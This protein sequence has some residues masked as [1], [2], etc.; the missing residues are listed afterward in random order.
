[1]YSKIHTIQHRFKL[2]A[3]SAL[4]AFQ[5]C[6]NVLPMQGVIELQLLVM[7]ISQPPQVVHTGETSL[8]KAVHVHGEPNGCEPSTHRRGVN[9]PIRAPIFQGCCNL[10]RGAMA[11][12]NLTEDVQILSLSL[13]LSFSLPLPLPPSLTQTDKQIDK[14]TDTF[15]V[16]FLT[17]ILPSCCSWRRRTKSRASPTISSLSLISLA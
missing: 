9:Q 16:F 4:Q 15:T 14:Q 2:V 3:I 8:G 12:S 13:S 11:D 6:H 5:P 1:M 7:A 10:C 17:P